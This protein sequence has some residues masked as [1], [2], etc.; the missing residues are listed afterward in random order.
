MK[1]IDP[2]PGER[3]RQIREHRELSQ[4]TIARA[5][6]VTIGA[7]QHYE[8]GRTRITTQRLEELSRAL[9]CEPA[10]LLMPPDSPPPRY[11]RRRYRPF[12][13]RRIA[14]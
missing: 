12:R 3:L 11:K 13:Q 7:I 4:G 8:Q 10:D 14:A 6:R 2:R 5:L 1:T 9:Q